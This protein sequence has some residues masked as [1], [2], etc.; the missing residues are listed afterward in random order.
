MENYIKIAILGDS[1]SEGLGKRKYNYEKY[2]KKEFDNAIVKN[3]AHTGTTIRYALEKSSEIIEFD[4]DI[5]LVFYGNV[6]AILRPNTNSKYNIYKLLPKRYKNN[7]MLDPRPFYS[8]NLISKSM[9][10]IESNLR[11]RVK[12]VL[13]KIQ[14]CYSWTDI[15]SFE[16]L[17]E[18]F[19]NE[20]SNDKN[21]I[22]LISTVN[23]DESYFP[24]SDEQ[25]IKY[26]K[27]IKDISER[28]NKLF[29]NLYDRLKVYD[30]DYIYGNDHFHPNLRGYE[31][32]GNILVN[33]IKQ[34]Y[35]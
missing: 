10:Y 20:I 19:I 27:I 13:M 24:G 5:T 2:I 14:G 29:V 1:I 17:Y 6:D 3:F 7:G 35:F 12:K 28:N 18:K 25:F 30:W 26:N 4:P 16:M 11:Y 22:I 23:I 8:G 9:Q 21:F 32:I 34:N 33:E 31:I 15:E